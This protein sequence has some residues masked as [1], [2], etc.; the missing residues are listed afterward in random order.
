M[1]RTLAAGLFALTCVGFSSFPGCNPHQAVNAEAR[2][3]FLNV[4]DMIEMTDKMAQSIIK[5]PQIHEAS[6]RGALKIVIKP[7]INESNEIIRDNRRELFVARL[8]GLLTKHAALREKFV[9]VMNREDFM[10]LRAQEFPESQLG[11]TEDRIQPEYALYATFLADTN[12]TRNRRSDTYLCQYKLT[13]ISGN[14][15][16]E[17]LWTDQFETSKQ[18]KKNFLD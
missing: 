16:N 4:D 5:D 13:R 2:T 17:I 7:V 3:T 14:N 15:T 1:K 18:I 12:V 11:P 8:Q 10:K 9:W 6:T